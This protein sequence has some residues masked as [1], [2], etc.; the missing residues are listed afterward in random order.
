[1]LGPEI[2]GRYDSLS[3]KVWEYIG[4]EAPV[5]TVGPENSLAGRLVETEG[6]GRATRSYDPNLAASMACEM[7]DQAD[8]YRGNRNHLAANYSW[9][10]IRQR[11][12][13]HVLFS[14]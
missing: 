12:L 8:A 14:R 5:L 9:R 11:Y 7:I 4:R 3:A 2:E 10:S 1:V 6:R 13:D